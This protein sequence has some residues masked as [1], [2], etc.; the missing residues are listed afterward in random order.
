MT[1]L[2]VKVYRHRALLK[3]F[4]RLNHE[5]KARIDERMSQMLEDQ[6]IKK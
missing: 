6:G 2:F 1:K 4:N 3:K 5:N